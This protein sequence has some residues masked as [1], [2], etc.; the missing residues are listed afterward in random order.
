MR[1]GNRGVSLRDHVQ[2]HATALSEYGY[3]HDWAARTG[4][5]AREKKRKYRKETYL[6]KPRPS[7]LTTIQVLASR[8]S[9][10]SKRRTYSYL[11]SVSASPPSSCR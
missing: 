6:E 7:I 10:C 11:E 9:G 4:D 2:I 1:A 8:M 3:L 5:L